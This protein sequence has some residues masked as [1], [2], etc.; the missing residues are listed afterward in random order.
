MN[1]EGQ[2]I[3]VEPSPP[4]PELLALAETLSSLIALIQDDRLVYVNPAGCALLGRPRESIVGRH[5]RDVVHPDD[6]EAAVARAKARAEGRAPR[7]VTERLV[8]ADGRTIWM[9][10]SIDVIRFEGRPT[11]LVTG[12]DVTD[13]LRMEEDLRRSESRLAE[14]QRI[15]HIGSWEWDIAA[16][17]ITWSD[18][19]C[20]IYGVE[21]EDFGGTVEGY[22]ALVHPED[23]ERSRGN[24]ERALRN[25]GPFAFE[26]RVVHKD[27]S[28]RT[29]FGSGEV[30]MDASG[31]PVRVA[32]TGQDITERRRMEEELRRSEERFRN[33][34]TQAPVMLMAFD[35]AGRIRDVS[36]HWLATTGYER[37]EVIGRE[38]WDFVTPE[39]RER[40]RKVKEESQKNHEAVTRNIPLQGVRK[41]GSTIDLLSTSVTEFDDAGEK[42]GAICV[43]INLTDLQRAEEALRESE[44]RYRAL[45]EHAPEAIMVLDVETGKFVDA[46]AR[47]EDLFGFPRERFLTMGPLDFCSEQQAD[48]RDSCEVLEEENEKVLAGETVE[49]EFTQV[50]ASGREIVCHTRLSKLPAAG[51]KLIRATVTDVTELKELQEKVRRAEKLAAVGVLA[52]GVAHEIGNPLMALTMAAESLERRTSDDYFR[53]KLAL[54]REHIGRI[55][56]IVHQMSDLARPQSGPKASSDLNRIVRRAVDMARHDQRSRDSEIR[57]EL[58]EALPAV[59]AVEDELTQVCINLALNAFDAMASNP[60]DRPRRL[61]IRSEAPDGL[62]RVCFHDSGPGVPPE[63]R[64]KLFEPFFTTKEVGRGSGLGLSVSYRILEEHGG[65]LRLDD[66]AESGASFV[67][68][69]PAAHAVS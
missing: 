15:S 67:I 57:Y 54:I 29:I 5:F 17:R 53:G 47:A 56:R 65:T 68:E 14:A 42:Q 13:R 37:S 30:F 61:T 44:E 60:A 35:P 18:E 36:D 69:M 49:F 34:C 62:V 45:V 32:G 27:G 55:S 12:N 59:L 38:G 66:E 50:H 43:Q 16:G 9:E 64:P 23:R 20:R 63:I 40:L 31:K 33:L 21:P 25:G 6:R 46:N 39:S 52:A 51:R 48:G 19:L 4:K 1:V 28:V 11:T 58:A 8:H 26:H 10:Y 41:D 2:E 22:L 3:V 24:L 7:R